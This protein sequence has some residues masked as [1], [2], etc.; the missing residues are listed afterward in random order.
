MGTLIIWQYQEARLL[1]IYVMECLATG[2]VLNLTL[3]CGSG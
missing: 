2:L 3:E 1:S